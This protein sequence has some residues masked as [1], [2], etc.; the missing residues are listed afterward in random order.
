MKNFVRRLGK[1]RFLLLCFIPFGAW[2]VYYNGWVGLVTAILAWC[3]GNAI[4]NWQDSKRRLKKFFSTHTELK[5]KAIIILPIMAACTYR[6]GWRGFIASL[7]GVAV[8]EFICR[9]YLFK[10]R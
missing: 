1:T 10:K 9:R 2:G 4:Y 7:V 3:F 8:G 5:V 6:S